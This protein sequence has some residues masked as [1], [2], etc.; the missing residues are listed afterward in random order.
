MWQ[1]IFFNNFQLNTVPNQ[2]VVYKNDESR[3]HSLEKTVKSLE[4]N[5]E[6][7]V[8]AVFDEKELVHRLIPMFKMA[9]PK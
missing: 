7:W 2:R 3:T 1:N 8:K 5:F 6:K 9:Q 4:K